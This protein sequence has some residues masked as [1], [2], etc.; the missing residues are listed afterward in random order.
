MYLSL[1][2]RA[3]RLLCANYFAHASSLPNSAHAMALPLALPI[4]LHLLRALLH[5][6]EAG[7]VVYLQRATPPCWLGR[8]DRLESSQYS[9]ASCCRGA[10]WT[11]CLCVDGR[12]RS[13][14]VL[15]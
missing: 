6:T 9:V 7:V 4:G 12:Q 3:W 10:A 14:R 11:L 13:F 5:C 1:L 2:L 15:P 8:C